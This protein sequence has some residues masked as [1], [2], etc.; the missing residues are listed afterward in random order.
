LIMG[1]TMTSDLHAKY[2]NL[3]LSDS[4]DEPDPEDS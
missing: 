2:L 1:K 4:P 3:D